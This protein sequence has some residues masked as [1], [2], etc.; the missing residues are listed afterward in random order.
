MQHRMMSAGWQIFL[1]DDARSDPRWQ[2]TRH[3]NETELTYGAVIPWRM[4]YVRA[5]V[6]ARNNFFQFFMKQNVRSDRN[7]KDSRINR[8]LQERGR[9][10]EPATVW[11]SARAALDKILSF[12]SA[13]RSQRFVKEKKKKRKKSSCQ[14]SLV[15]PDYQDSAGFATAARLSIATT[16]RSTNSIVESR[17]QRVSTVPPQ[18]VSINYNATPI[19][20]F[21]SDASFTARSH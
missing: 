5:G 19:D 21:V 2:E 7:D 8:A 10:I 6:A 9:V 16:N 11:P 12:L 15:R 17:A 20:P 14:V 3:Y 13:S 1:I 4:R 18:R